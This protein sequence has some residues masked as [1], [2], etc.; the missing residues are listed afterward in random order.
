M[1]LHDP[2][3]LP[4]VV[5]RVSDGA[6]SIANGQEDGGQAEPDPIWDMDWTVVTYSRRW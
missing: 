6:V 5:S 4:A 1:T 2:E 3:L